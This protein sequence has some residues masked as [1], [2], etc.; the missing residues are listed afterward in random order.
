M[1]KKLCMGCMDYYDDRYQVC[2]HCGYIEGTK[3]KEA[4]HL[5]PGTVLSGRY[6]VGKVIGF[7]GF[8]ITYIGYDAALKHKIAIKE[9]LP[10]EFATRCEGDSAVTVFS[11]DEKHEQFSD[12]IVKFVDEAKRLAKFQNVEGVVSIFDSFKENNTAYIV[13]EYL[14]GETLR[15]KIEREK[16]IDFVESLNYIIPILDALTE[17]HKEGILHRDISPDNIFVTNDNQVKLIDFGA[18]RYA[19]TTHSKSLSVIVKPGY[20]PMEQYR[21]RGDQGSWTDV[22]AC[23]AVLYKMITGITPE[24]AMERGEKDTL[25]APSK[26]GVRLPR[27]KENALM[28]ALNLKIEDRTQTPEAFKEEL[29][30]NDTVR[31]KK[32]TLR[33]LDIGRWP[34]WARVSS[35]ASA[36]AVAAVILL[37]ATGV[38]HFDFSSMFRGISIGNQVRIPN[39]VSTTLDE[40]SSA[41]SE[42]EIIVQ[43]VDKQNS[44]EIP[45][46]LVLS[47][48]ILDGQVVDKGTVVDLV[49]SA[50]GEVVYMPDLVGYIE[51]DAVRDV[52]ELGLNY[53][54]KTEPSEIAPGYVTAQSVI[55]GTAI[56]KGNEVELVISSGMDSYDSTKTTEVPDFVG[57]AWNKAKETAG[58]KKLYIYIT[59]KRY[60]E[61]VPKDE[62]ISQDIDKGTEVPE[63]TVVGLV[64]SLGIEQTH[65]PD[66]QYKSEKEAEIILTDAKLKVRVEH[67]DSDKVQK[68]HV[69]RQDIA[70]GTEVDV[71]SEVTIYVSN[72]NE[73]AEK[74]KEANPNGG[75]QAISEAGPVAEGNPEDS[76]NQPGPSPGDNSGNS[77]G[78]SSSEDNSSKDS[79]GAS[80]EKSSNGG[81]STT[82]SATEAPE[83]KKEF[84]YWDYVGTDET[85]LVNDINSSGDVTVGTVTRKS[86]DSYLDGTVMATSRNGNYIDYTVCDNSTHTQYRY[87]TVSS[88]ETTTTTTNSA[89]SSEYSYVR[90]ESST[91]YSDYG[92]WSGW[93]PT[94][95]S[96]N[97]TTDVR[98]TS[99]RLVG[100]Y[101]SG[102]Y[103][104]QNDSP[105]ADWGGD[106]SEV[107]WYAPD[108]ELTL[109][110]GVGH[111]R[112]NGPASY[113]YTP[114]GWAQQAPYWGG[115]SKWQWTGTLYS[116]RTRT[117]TVTTTYYWQKPIWSGWS[118]WYDELPE[119]VSGLGSGEIITEEREVNDY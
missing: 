69:I 51:A 19:T 15:E 24:D 79:T 9:Y 83:V 13:M 78:A 76:Q 3:P 2:P 53:I 40:A 71:Y 110:Y 101:L 99:G 112:Q 23:A 96:K 114:P 44:D 68:D 115:D 60:S 84:P 105:M 87:K 52:E 58:K 117:K 54:K 41:M 29:L 4:Y 26:L 85:T 98:T 80:S 77:D 21:S 100:A 7:G 93:S 88:Y 65:V 103:P 82:E 32:S 73:A 92:G 34:M 81:T 97:E 43:V 94:A 46:D 6:I 36:V 42:K 108:N 16:H 111:Y 64:V 106:Y 1:A 35:S 86:S 102:I 14:E 109:R 62:I 45:K 27:N 119:E 113:W 11:S 90:E 37:M 17:I 12:G 116:Y 56:E 31:K 55:P 47:Q 91:S 70:A 5:M 75:Q 72:G 118:S 22:Y 25:E 28:N 39:V 59:E 66:V 57:L 10:G 20:A 18:A 33:K 89:P 63:G 30:T 48:S 50:G 104:Y 61:N 95:V 74:W 38:I 107:A 67:E 49:I 8:G